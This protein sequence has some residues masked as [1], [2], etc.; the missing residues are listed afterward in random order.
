ME[1]DGLLSRRQGDEDKR[2]TIVSL[3]DAGRE[4]VDG[5]RSAHKQHAAEFLSPLSD[6][7]KQQLAEILKKLIESKRG[8]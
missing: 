4:K 2:Q 6:S 5:F 7:E 8:I 3:T 1:N